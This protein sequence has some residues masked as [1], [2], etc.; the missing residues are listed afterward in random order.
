MSKYK[1][2]NID[3]LSE[4]RELLENKPNKFTNYFIYIILALIQIW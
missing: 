1:I 3:E 4:S 2:Q